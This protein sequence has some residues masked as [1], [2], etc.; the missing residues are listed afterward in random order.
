MKDS[1]YEKDINKNIQPRRISP[2]QR[3]YCFLP[4]MLPPPDCSNGTRKTSPPLQNGVSCRP[5]RFAQQANGGP[6]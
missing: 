2:V 5:N 1:N 4:H 6:G 3:R